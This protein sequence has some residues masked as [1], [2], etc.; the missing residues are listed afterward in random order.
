[1]SSDS[2]KSLAAAPREDY[3]HGDGHPD[4]FPGEFRGRK[5][6]DAGT[7]GPY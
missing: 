5:G 4:L 6:Y 1:M 3:A 2:P 7:A